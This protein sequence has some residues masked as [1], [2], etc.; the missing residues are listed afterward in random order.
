MEVFSNQPCLQI[1]NAWLFDG[2]D[3]G[4]QGKPYQFSGGFIFETQGFPDAPNHKNFP[5]IKLYPGERYR[6]KT[7]YIFSREN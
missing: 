3:I 2:T 6:H 1:Y 5:S 4:K 7:K